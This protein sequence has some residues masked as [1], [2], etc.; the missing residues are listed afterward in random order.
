MGS[1]H[2]IPIGFPVGILRFPYDHAWLLPMV[3]PHE[4]SH[5][6]FNGI[7]E[8]LRGFLHGDSSWGVSLGRAH[9]GSSWVFPTRIVHGNSTWGSPTGIPMRFPRVPWGLPMVIPQGDGDSIWG[10][11]SIF[12]LGQAGWS[13]G[14]IGDSMGGPHGDS[15]WPTCDQALCGYPHW[16]CGDPPS[17]C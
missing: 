6:A 4:N 11:G 10:L 1:P 13:L 16:P 12:R 5:V 9:A 17:T 8:I 2:G 3:N 15:A 14:W 7:P